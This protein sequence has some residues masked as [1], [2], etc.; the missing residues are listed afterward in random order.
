[1]GNVQL[2]VTNIGG[3]IREFTGFQKEVVLSH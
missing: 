2:G 1:M 3:Q